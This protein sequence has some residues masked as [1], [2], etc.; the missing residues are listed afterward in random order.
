MGR[1]A[2]EKTRK[3]LNKK[4]EGWLR[5]LFPK[6]QDKKLNRL[7]LDEIAQL[8]GKSKSTIYSYFTTKEEIYQ[9]SVTLI[10]QDLEE[11]IYSELPENTSLEVLYGEILLKLSKGINGISIH[12][13]HQIQSHFPAI[14][15]LIMQYTNKFLNMLKAIYEKGMATGEFRKFNTDLLMAMDNHFVLSIMTATGRFG[16]NGITLNELVMEYLELRILAL[17]SKQ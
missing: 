5:A 15:E 1:K 14:W 4:A 17:R 11:T 3:P 12:F 13:L 16:K 2:L 6:L 9:N 7:T 10:L 8:M